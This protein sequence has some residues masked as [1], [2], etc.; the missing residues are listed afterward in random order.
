MRLLTVAQI[1]K[2]FGAQQ[3]LQ[4]V[5][6]T[7]DSG[8]VVHIAGGNGSGKSTLL[9]IVAGIIPATSGTFQL[10]ENTHIG[11]LIENPGFLEGESLKTNLT[12]LA[13]INHHSDPAVMAGLAQRFGLDWHS[14]QSMK[15]YSIG[16]REKAG[17]IQ[18]VM[19]DQ[20]LILLDEPTRGLDE[21]ALTQL[22][23][24]VAELRTAGKAVIIASHDRYTPITYTANYQLEGGRLTRQSDGV[25]FIPS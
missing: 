18:A 12:F 24:L 13:A 1:A 17:I 22:V 2:S 20:N 11:A 19:E 4:D 7:V 5:S 23:N 3:V 14:R 21:A 8:E 9:K 6:L 10:G 16:M 25:L 15:K